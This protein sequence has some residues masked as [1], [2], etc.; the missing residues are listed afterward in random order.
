MD[1]FATNV[2]EQGWNIRWIAKLQEFVFSSAK[3]II[4]NI[5]WSDYFKWIW[6]L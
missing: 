4:E 1:N 5:L 6:V 2:D 3:Y